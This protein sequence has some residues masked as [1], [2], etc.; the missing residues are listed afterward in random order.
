MGERLDVLNGDGAVIHCK[1]SLAGS[2]VLV[3]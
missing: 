1:V 3:Q 2:G